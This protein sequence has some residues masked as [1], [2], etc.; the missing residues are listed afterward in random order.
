MR[1]PTKR[2]ARL[3]TG[4]LDK[5]I[6]DAAIDTTTILDVQLSRSYRTANASQPFADAQAG[7][8]LAVLLYNVGGRNLS[9]TQA[10]FA[11]HP[12]WASA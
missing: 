4:D 7:K 2:I 12:D 11:R 8:W 1:A 3:A 6:E 10:D 9:D 5:A